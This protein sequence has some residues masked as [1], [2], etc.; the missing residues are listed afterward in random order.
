[1]WQPE[2]FRPLLSPT[3]DVVAAN[4]WLKSSIHKLDLLTHS[5]LKI[6]YNPEE[7]IA[8]DDTTGPL[9][10]ITTWKNKPELNIKNDDAEDDIYYP[11]EN[12]VDRKPDH[13]T[14]RPPQPTYPAPAPRDTPV[15]LARLAVNSRPR[16][17]HVRET[18]V[19]NFFQPKDIG[20]FYSKRNLYKLKE[21]AS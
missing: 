14:V 5:K 2:E 6:R 20:T 16:H 13:V 8:I 4:E 19:E 18:R 21:W 11:E 3:A 9:W 7:Y 12:D 17:P 1:M 15:H 10:N